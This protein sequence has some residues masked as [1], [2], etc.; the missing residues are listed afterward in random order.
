MFLEQPADQLFIFVQGG[1]SR[2]I[3]SNGNLGDHITA[4]HMCDEA[5]MK[6][7]GHPNWH[8]NVL[9][10]QLE[11]WPQG[12]EIQVRLN[13]LACAIIQ[14]FSPD[15]SLLTF[16]TLQH[17]LFLRWVSV[18]SFN[19]RDLYRSLFLWLL[20]LVLTRW[21]GKNRLEAKVYR[22]SR[23]SLIVTRTKC[24]QL[25]WQK[26]SKVECSLDSLLKKYC[27]HTSKKG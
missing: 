12:R 7:A 5:L 13:S 26:T 14:I 18:R 10:F 15:R 4:S 2:A 8:W 16:K 19:F 11:K 9:Q 24:L 6:L 21:F 23:L 27:K 1:T 22:V 25:Q 20:D 17:P 3:I